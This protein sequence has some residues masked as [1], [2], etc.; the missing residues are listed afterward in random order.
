MIENDNK[1]MT[2]ALD[3]LVHEPSKPARLMN[4]V[5]LAYAGDA[6]YELLVRQYLISKPNHQSH[7]LHRE[8]TKRVSAKAQRVTLEKLAPLLTEE[9]ADIVRRGRNAKSGKPPKN[10]DPADY[11]H[12]TALETL[13]GYLFYERRGERIRELLAVALDDEATMR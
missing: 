2:E 7:E 11:R 4:P 10:A 9:E 5:V 6:V 3:L 13:F 12:A 8:A 1:T